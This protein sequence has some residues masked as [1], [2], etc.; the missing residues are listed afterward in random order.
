LHIFSC[1]FSDNGF[2]ITKRKTVNDGMLINKIPK[3]V[4]KI[5]FVK[6]FKYKIKKING[7]KKITGSQII[8]DIGKTKKI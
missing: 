5:F 2:K 6:F 1:P 8:N 3:I 4:F 7:K